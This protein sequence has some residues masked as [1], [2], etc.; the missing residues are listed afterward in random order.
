MRKDLRIPTAPGQ[1]IVTGP[2]EFTFTK[3]TA[4]RV[5]RF[6]SEV[7]VD[8]RVIGMGRT[9]GDAA[10]APSTL[11][12]MFVARDEASLE[13]QE[14][15]GQRFGPGGSLENGDTF[16]PGLPPVEFTATFEFSEKYRPGKTLVF[17][18][19]QLEF[20]DRSLLGTGEKTWNNGDRFFFVN[21]PLTTLPDDL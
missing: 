15:N 11:N 14:A 18:V 7:I 5:E 21:L 16:T 3:A 4:Q 6:G 1:V 10:I 19:A 20:T 13:I 12:P 2:Y 9:T 8:V 17:A